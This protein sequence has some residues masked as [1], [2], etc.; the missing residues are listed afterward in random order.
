MVMAE[1]A[2]LSTMPRRTPNDRTIN[3]PMDLRMA[4]MAI[5]TTTLSHHPAGNLLLLELAALPVV[6]H[7]LYQILTDPM[8]VDNPK[9]LLD[10]NNLPL[11]MHHNLGT[12]HLLDDTMIDDVVVGILIEE[13]I[14]DNVK[15]I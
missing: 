11:I 2:I 15:G 9:D 10:T 12:D 7:P 1:D 6:L 3:N 14:E 13:I 5:I 8:V 4:T